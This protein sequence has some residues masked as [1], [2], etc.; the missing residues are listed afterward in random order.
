MRSSSLVSERP[1]LVAA[2]AAFLCLPLEQNTAFAQEISEHAPLVPAIA[3]G[4]RAITVSRASDGLGAPIVFEGK[5]DGMI[6]TTDGSAPSIRSL[7]LPIARASV[8]SHYGMRRHPV[9]GSY[10]MHSGVD[11]AAP[12][13]APIMAPADGVVSHSQW[14]GSYG[15]FVSL[16]H[17]G[18]LQTRFAHLSQLA[19][20]AGQRVQRGQILGY[21]GSTGRSTG[22]HLHYEIRVDGRSVD[23]LAR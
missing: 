14:Y 5:E 15:L 19:V 1:F 10:R 22:P 3:V 13:G 4:S 9:L 12:L 11:F 20:R 21:V 6:S 17:W 2:A 18:G 7:S 23:P 8:T 16:E